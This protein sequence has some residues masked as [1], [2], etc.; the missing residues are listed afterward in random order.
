MILHA[1]ELTHVARFRD[2]VAI[3]PLAPGLNILATPNETGKTTALTATARALFDRHTT[4]SDELHALRPAATDLAPRIA[5]DFETREGIFRI[6]KTF[7]Q[8]PRSHLHRRTT[9]TAITAA[10]A[11]TWELIAEADA[12]DQRLQTLLQS[13]LP[14]RGSTRPEHWG[15]LGFLWARQGDP[16]DWPALDGTDTTRRIRARLARVELDPLIERLRARLAAIAAAQLTPGGKPKAGGPLATAGQ[17]LA[18][19]EDELARLRKTRDE[20]EA[21]HQRHQQATEAVAQLEKE[22]ATRDL[23]AAQ[24]RAQTLDAERLRGELA[25][26]QQALDTAT[27]KLTAITNDTE[28]L[29]RLRTDTAATQ[30]LLATAATTAAD[31]ETR[32]AEITARL[33]TLSAERPRHET[34]LQT[35]R[36]D[37]QRTQTLLKH[38]RHTAEAAALRRQLDKAEIHAASH[39]ALEAEKLKL[40]AITPAALRKLET[41]DESIREKRAQ[42][43]A[44]GLTVDLTP[45]HPA[46]ARIAT[47]GGAA[48]PT[49]LPACKTTRL[50]SPQTLDVE[51]AGWGRITI[52]SGS[53][54]TQ[55]LAAD[56]AAAET[57]LSTALETA[58]LPTLSAARETIAARKDLDA[59]I[60]TAATALETQLGDHNTIDTLRHAAATAAQRAALL[61]TPPTPAT[62]AEKNRPDITPAAQ[63]RPDA[64]LEAD[65]AR[66]AET[67]AATEKT[68]RQLD[69]QLDAQRAAERAAVQTHAQALSALTDHRARLRA[70][71]TRLA[72]LTARHAA[73][74]GLDA[75]KTAAQLAFAQA[76]ARVAAT[77]ADLPPDYEKLPERNRRAAA[78][79][80]QLANELQTRR[81]ERDQARGTLETI[82]GQGL[83]TRET[84]LEEKKTE[85]TLRRDAARAQA[86]SARLAHD[87]IEHRKQAATKALL[88]PL[89]TRLTTA[90]S[91]ITGDTAR[92]VYLDDRLQIAGLGRTREEAHPFA[93]LSQGA[94]EQLLLCLRLA[95]AQE[96]STDEPQLLILD[97]VLVNTDPVRQER[98]LD[99]LAAQTP[100]LQILILTC[101]PDRYRGVGHPLGFSIPA[102]EQ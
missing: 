13:S 81:A 92:R 100:R 93:Q 4:K 9:A 76:E 55:H 17:D 97:D 48:A 24:L 20:L 56:L 47:T 67:I 46:T 78:A 33:E 101:H 32:L 70:L 5:V 44:L 54:E 83:Y 39:A 29:A 2:T 21:A 84:E 75:A 3:G 77:K 23:A 96:L 18:A 94:K 11:A 58:A 25:A 31:A 98:I 35:H 49:P 43:Q 62:T 65:E 60:K 8:S 74:G 57:A 40:P 34:R 41:L 90:F 7:L 38:R 59:R 88:A 85:A 27:E 12:A 102:K 71:E 16:A 99:T 52:R 19:I 36:D 80:Q 28:T 42:L 91:E 22:H 30:T 1:I 82:G 61:A 73:S 86:L 51:L 37:A 68:L 72:D 45:N 64:D 53:R 14:G 50:H 69:R 63:T 87:L 66:L 26:R 79:L 89:E 15:L 10:A 95:G 6:E